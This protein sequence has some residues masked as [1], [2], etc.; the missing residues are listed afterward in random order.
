MNKSFSESFDSFN[1]LNEQ[2]DSGK[3]LFIFMNEFEQEKSLKRASQYRARRPFEL[4]KPKI[5]NLF[6]K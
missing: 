5:C 4:I 6:I 1:E 2:I 3:D